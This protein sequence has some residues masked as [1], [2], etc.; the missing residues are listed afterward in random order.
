MTLKQINMNLAQFVDNGKIDDVISFQDIGVLF[1]FELEV[2]LSAP[3]KQVDPPPVRQPSIVEK[4][5]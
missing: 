3:Q 1:V 4:P 5:P 2:K